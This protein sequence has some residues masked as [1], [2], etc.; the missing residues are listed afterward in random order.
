DDA[1][2]SWLE[3]TLG[4]PYLHPPLSALTDSDVILALNSNLDTLHPQALAR[5]LAAQR[6]GAKLIVLDEV[7]GRAA[8]VADVWLQASP[9]ELGHTLELLVQ[10]MQ[11]RR[12][13]APGG[14]AAGAQAPGVDEALALLAGAERAAI[15]ASAAALPAACAASAGALA[16][17]VSGHRSAA[18]A[19]YLLRSEAN[20]LG[21]A[22]MGLAPGR[23][24]GTDLWALLDEQRSLAATVMVDEDLARL[25]GPEA[26]ARL[27]PKLGALVVLAAFPSPTTELAD[28][29][30]PVA[31]IGQ[32][33]GSMMTGDGRVWWL[34]AITGA[35]GDARPAVQ[36]L[37]DLARRM[38]G[39]SV[40]PKPEAVWE[41]AR[42]EI[43]ACRAVDIE[44]LR[45]GEPVSV[46]RESLAPSPEPAGVAFA[47]PELVDSDPERPWVLVVRPDENDRAFDPR[48]RAMVLIE[49]D[50]RR[51]R[52]PYVSMSPEDLAERRIRP[53]RRVQIDTRYGKAE[54][55][56]RQTEG[57]PAGMIVLPHHFPDLRRVLC[58][59]GE[60]G[61]CGGRQWRPVWAG[62]TPI[63]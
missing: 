51:G 9:G 16:K 32:R 54:L 44:A 12:A 34:D 13:G 53:G 3:Q 59:A 25:I 27:R 45:A 30:L 20:S 19:I 2:V 8:G 46:L 41:Q 7:R 52:A 31:T 38:G 63:G 4:E 49:R 23:A 60:P 50:L 6:R 21:T 29:V 48:V 24:D 35:P 18:D 57:I 10:G 33:E 1:A 39:R 61:A 14:N 17:L 58:G 56:V 11:S 28:V 62:L 42:W 47:V 26:L 37:A 15:V 22:L 43:P 36:V 55:Q 5:V 40:G